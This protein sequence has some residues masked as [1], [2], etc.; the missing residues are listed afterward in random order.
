MQ[1]TKSIAEANAR[2]AE[3]N[4]IAEQERLAR[5]QLEA[6]L[7]PRGLNAEQA[8]DLIDK[9]KPFAGQKFDL[10]IYSNDG[11]VVFFT[12][13]LSNILQLSGWTGQTWSV[14]GGR[15]VVGIVVETIDG[16]DQQT[17]EAANSFVRGLVS[18]QIGAVG[19]TPF[20]KDDVPGALLTGPAWNKN[21]LS[22]IRI[23]V[24]KKLL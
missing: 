17:N 14:S 7:A 3:A 13:V 12:N 4:K 18:A 1:L 6:I 2:A 10:F 16:A 8:N 15:T 21:K 24:G 19:P 9:L 11:E 22:P 23:M 20:R 5:L